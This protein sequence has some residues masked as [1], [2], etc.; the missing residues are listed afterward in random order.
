MDPITSTESIVS[1]ANKLL[2]RP[3]SEQMVAGKKHRNTRRIFR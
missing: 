2:V 1:N 3:Y